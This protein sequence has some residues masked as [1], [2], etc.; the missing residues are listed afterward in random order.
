MP[1]FLLPKCVT[2]HFSTLIQSQ[3][4]VSGCQFRVWVALSRGLTSLHSVDSASVLPSLGVPSIP[5]PGGDLAPGFRPSALPADW[6]L[7][8]RGPHRLVRGRREGVLGN[9][10]ATSVQRPQGPL[11]HRQPIRDQQPGLGESGLVPMCGFPF[12]TEPANRER[13]QDER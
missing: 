9:Q 3:T 4:V 11:Q 8:T 5:V 6:V 12:R 10:P 7:P 1:P 2:S 13:D